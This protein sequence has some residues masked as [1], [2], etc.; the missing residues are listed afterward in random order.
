MDQTVI[1]VIDLA[2]RVL[3]AHAARANGSVAFRKKLS[4]AQLVP[5]FAT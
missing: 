1:I 4:R 2:T 3:Q 5:F